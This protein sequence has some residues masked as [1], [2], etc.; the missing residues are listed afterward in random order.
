MPVEILVGNIASG[1]STYAKERARQGALVVSMDAL[2]TALHGGLY[3]YDKELK[4][5]YR[6]IQSALITA[7]IRTGRDVVVDDRNHTEVKRGRLIAIA[8]AEGEPVAATV[9]ER[10][11]P[12]V[13][14]DRRV[15]AGA[16]GVSGSKWFEVADITDREWQEPNAT[17]GLNSITYIK[18]RELGDVQ[19]ETEVGR[20]L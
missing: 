14:S 6:L 18:H 10:E 16:R 9:F 3:A 5:T 2:L 11:D 19:W 7:A 20:V 12:M 1:K 15:K 17:E 8:A 13:H 4:E